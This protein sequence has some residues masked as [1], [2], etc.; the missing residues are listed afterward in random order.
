M[1]VYLKYIWRN[2]SLLFG[3]LFVIILHFTLIYFTFQARQVKIGN[4]IHKSIEDIDL[5]MCSTLFL[6]IIIFIS[7]M[8]FL[9]SNPGYVKK[10]KMNDRENIVQKLCSE[11]EYKDP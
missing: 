1:K 11:F 8:T 10:Q 2:T 5:L 4:E 3:T 9:L 7:M 6:D